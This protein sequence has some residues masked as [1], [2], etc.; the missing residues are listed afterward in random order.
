MEIAEL[1]VTVIYDNYN[2]KKMLQPKLK[3]L[4]LKIKQFTE[5]WIPN[6]VEDI[7]EIKCK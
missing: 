7:T 6:P 1:F 2:Y 5:I 4:I 3:I